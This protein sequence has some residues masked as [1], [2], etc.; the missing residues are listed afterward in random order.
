MTHATRSSRLR[1]GWLS[2]AVGLLVFGGKFGAF[3][4]TGSTAV[5][6]DALESIVNVAAGALLVFSLIVAARPPD[7]DH[8]Y[9]HGKVE[10]FSA[11]IEGAFVFGAGGLILFEAA[12]ALLQG[13]ELQRLGAGLGL[14][15]VFG[16]VNALLGLYLVRVG[17]RTR[18]AALLADGKHVLADVWTTV[19]VIAGLVA[20]SLTGWLLLDPLIA[21]AVGLHVLRE[22]YHLVRDAIGGLMDAADAEELEALA[23][24]LEKRRA[25]S[26]IDLHALRAWRSGAF[27][28]ADLHLVIPRY[29]DA[30]ALH[31]IHDEVEAALQDTVGPDSDTV[32]HF[33]P[34]RPPDCPGC[35]V[36]DCPVRS[37]PFGHRRP[38]AVE[39]ATRSDQSV[40]EQVYL[41]KV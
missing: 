27:L 20:V 40:E 39:H 5:L 9:G 31:G 14:L 1:A 6:S 25:E 19:A 36:A 13:P 15:A 18:S 10:F 33:D 21:L 4:L 37:T 8:P 30:E 28:H 2:L 29:L 17:R 41:A 12:R 22:G 35:P 16:G 23:S 24:A 38:F 3:L 34:C 11:G 26:W 32:V 7:R